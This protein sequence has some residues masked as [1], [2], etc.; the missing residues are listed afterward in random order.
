MSSCR[1]S[2]YHK[3]EAR[4]R[5]VANWTTQF[6]A[7]P[8]RYMLWDLTLHK[9]VTRLG[10]M[11]IEEMKEVMRVNQS[12][13]GRCI[14]QDLTNVRAD[15]VSTIAESYRWIPSFGW[16]KRFQIWQHS[17][18]ALISPS[19]QDGEAGHPIYSLLEGLHYFSKWNVI[20]IGIHVASMLG[21]YYIH[22]I[23]A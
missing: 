23:Q 8:T 16:G 18:K 1:S 22:R 10:D 4:I 13:D 3:S 20:Q 12:R 7:I 15:G 17:S 2:K 21:E 14:N 19:R 9:E 11:L 6:S 5:L